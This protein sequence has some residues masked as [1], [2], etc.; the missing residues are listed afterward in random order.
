[1]LTSL[2]R[3][4]DPPAPA[5]APVVISTRV[6]VS[7]ERAIPRA[8]TTAEIG[9][10]I[11]YHPRY[12][13][14]LRRAGIRT[15]KAAYQLPGEIVAGHPDRHVVRGEL[16]MGLAKKCVYLKREHI[17][18][19]RFKFR[20]QREGF[21]WVS[22][23]ER[24]AVV[25]RTLEEQGLPG[26]QWLAYGEDAEGRGFLL[27]DELAEAQDLRDTLKTQPDP[28]VR[29]TGIRQA[30]TMIAKVH[31]AGFT[32]P[33]L[34]AKHL[35][36][37]PS[38]VQATLIDWQSAEILDAVDVGKI[39][40][41]LANF[42]ASLPAECTVRD[43]VK[44]LVCY[45]RAM[46]K[47]GVSMPKLA[48]LSHAIE[49]ATEPRAKKSNIRDQQAGT[50]QR[51]VWLAG[52]AVC[53]IPEVAAE[54]P[55]PADG[56][57]FYV[58]AESGPQVEERV[59]L[60]SGRR[61]VLTRFHTCDPWGRVVAALREKP[62]RSPAAKA[63]RI[64]FHLERHAIP[65]PRLLAFGQ[66]NRN[67]HTC[68]SFLLAEPTPPTTGMCVRLSEAK[69]SGH[70]H[71]QLLV[72]AGVLLRRLH[73]ARLR[74]VLG[75]TGRPVFNLTDTGLMLDSPFSVELQRSI[76]PQER[77]SDVKRF[78]QCELAG[79]SQADQARFTLGYLGHD[80]ADRTTRRKFLANLR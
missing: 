38:S 8:R 70:D 7:E 54:W 13:V 65:A 3:T 67:R 53:A 60:A 34:T 12:E 14:F 76:T 5:E 50:P 73:E 47:L 39:T 2:F 30:A 29:L 57:P 37:N 58:E 72:Q 21:G 46:M 28:E 6:S 43:R 26:P 18:S 32:T 10:W 23:A 77:A 33:D 16:V 48:A 74:L 49:I 24:E 51:L 17:S 31:A 61:A 4:I 9:G 80:W 55:T 66:R 52:E 40:K 62:W 64:L 59:T 75:A 69:L 71:R 11:V 36:V 41:Q 79:L 1:M 35:F 68:D 15:A 27:V 42:A 78:I 44:F 45:R 20:N 63:G 25:L 22:R 19:Y 56:T